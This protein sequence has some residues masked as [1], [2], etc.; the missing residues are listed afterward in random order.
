M[1][2][3]EPIRIIIA[4][5]HKMFI[6]GLKSLLRKHAHIQVLGEAANG[7]EAIQLLEKFKHKIDISVLDIDMPEMNGV[8]ATKIILEKFPEVKI[9]ILTM[10]DE[11]TFIKELI[12]V[13][14]LG[15][16]LKDRGKEDFVEA[17]ETI[18]RGE[19]YLKG[20]VLGNYIAINKMPEP[21]VVHLTK[22]ELQVLQLLV[23]DHTS[24]EIAIK[25]KIAVSTVDTYR[26]NLIEKTGVKSSL[27]LVKYAIDN[28]LIKK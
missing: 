24:G 9:L 26:R 23:E 2:K 6:Q 19:E 11:G 7:K 3:K 1:K 14:V 20:E 27:G 13:G 4:D 15:Y 25:L 12:D 18:A 8:A 16:I 28:N 5:D 22:R 10:H 21:K 17:L